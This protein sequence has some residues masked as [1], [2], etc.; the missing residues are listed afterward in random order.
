[1]ANSIAFSVG[2]GGSGSIIKSIQRGESSIYTLHGSIDNYTVTGREAMTMTMNQIPISTVDP[3]K[4]IILVNN[5][6]SVLYNGGSRSAALMP[7]ITVVDFQ[8]KYFTCKLAFEYWSNEWTELDSYSYTDMYGFF[9]SGDVGNA[10][11]LYTCESFVIS[12]DPEGTVEDFHY[13]LE[14]IYEGS[15]AHGTKVDV[16]TRFYRVSYQIIEFY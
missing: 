13:W 14:N 11:S 3:S 5:V 15:T 10:E 16:P 8:P 4:S 6:S 12:G 2:S 7:P 9:N 1:M